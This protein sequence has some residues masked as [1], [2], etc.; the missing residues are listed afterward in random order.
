ME[1]DGKRAPQALRARQTHHEA[2]REAASARPRTPAPRSRFM[3]DPE[4]FT[5]LDFNF[6]TL[7]ARLRELAFLNSGMHD[8]AHATSA[9]DEPQ[10]RS[11]S[12][13]GG[14]VEFVEYLN[15]Q[16]EAAAPEAG[17]TSTATQDDIER[18][19]RPAVQ[20]R[21]QR[22]HLLL[23]E[24][25]QHARGRHPPHRLPLGAHPHAQQL[26]REERRAQE[27]QGL[28]AQRR[29]RARRAHR[30]LSREGARAAVRGADQDQAGQLEV[31]GIV[32][33]IVNE[34]PRRVPRG[35]PAVGAQR[36]STRRV[37]AA[38]ARARPPARRATCA[39]KKSALENVG[40]CP[41]SS[42][43]AR[44]DDPALCEIFIVEGDS[45]G[46]SRQ[47]GPRPRVPGHPAAARQDPQRR[48]GPHRQ[49][50]R[51][52]GNPHDHHRA[53]ARASTRGV[54]HRPS[55]ATTRSSS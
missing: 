19:D 17:A 55:C 54:R 25:H 14:I 51:Q 42:P 11:S 52:R 2:R 50:P 10:T 37:S 6:D 33:T 12:H 9:T 49:D 15:E 32:E 27:G 40:H 43:T 45:A 13:K 48:E 44:C 41:A 22:E 21:L 35:E 38:P 7:A 36:S 5:E 34:R 30:V 8:H 46:G 39:R 26:R 53:S 16:Q 28:H 31:E 24:Q 4:I 47:A 20:R 29:R 1:R 3:P 18:R 23:R